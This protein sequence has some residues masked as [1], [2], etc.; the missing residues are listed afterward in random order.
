M[1]ATFFTPGWIVDNH[2]TK[3][4]MVLDGGHELAH[5]GYEHH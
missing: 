1:M 5:H 2:S 3:E 4:G